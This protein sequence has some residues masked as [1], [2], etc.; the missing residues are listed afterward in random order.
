MS[1]RIQRSGLIAGG[2]SAVPALAGPAIYLI[3]GQS[4]AMGPS[5]PILSPP[6]LPRA[7]VRCSV[8][9]G[10][11]I[12]G[13]SPRSLDQFTFRGAEVGLGVALADAGR[14]VAI[15]KWIWNATSML[16]NWTPWMGDASASTINAL[17]SDAIVQ[18]RTFVE[19]LIAEDPAREP[20]VAGAFWS[21]WESDAAG[22]LLNAQM[23]V[24]E[25]RVWIDR[26]RA[27][28]HP[29]L[30]IF[31]STVS[32]NFAGDPGTYTLDNLAAISA[33]H[34]AVASEYDYVYLVNTDGLAFGDAIHYTADAQLE[35][36]RD[37]IAPLALAAPVPTYLGN[38]ALRRVS[39]YTSKAAAEAAGSPVYMSPA[40][41]RVWAVEDAAGA[42]FIP[43]AYWPV[44]VDKAARF[45]PNVQTLSASK[46]IGANVLNG[47]LGV[48]NTGGAWWIRVRF[49]FASTSET[50]LRRIMHKSTAY[51][52]Y[53]L[54]SSKQLNLRL[55]S[56]DALS[57]ASVFN[58][59][60]EAVLAADGAGNASFYKRTPGGVWTLI[61]TVAQ[62]NTFSGSATTLTVGS[63]SFAVAN[64]WH[65]D[66][67]EPIAGVFTP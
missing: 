46:V 29:D 41:S 24:Q 52:F 67:Y 15:S 35:L 51:S 33:A 19:Q 39:I 32:D 53:W 44:V 57:L 49:G 65:G 54:G 5:D 42:H 48:V 8:Y 64:Q 55:N 7:D 21:Q 22:T 37:R 47:D 26:V 1:H 20:Y 66:I 45:F 11:V 28:Y 25:L 10:G 12:D 59:D 2:R 4:N 27:E 23:Y 43:S 31:I 40:D 63:G 3:A 34:A 60:D 18:T 16:S 38:A 62:A 30:P 17:L 50:T 56:V 61:N 36:G 14:N 13:A 6:P 9:H 58:V